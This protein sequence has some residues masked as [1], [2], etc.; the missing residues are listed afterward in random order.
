MVFLPVS[1]LFGWTSHAHGVQTAGWLL[2]AIVAGAALLV[3]RTTTPQ[4][5][6]TALAQLEPVGALG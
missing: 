1:L 6:P 5:A 3:V 2:V 4:I